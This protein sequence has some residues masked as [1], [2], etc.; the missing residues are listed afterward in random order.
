MYTK[1]LLSLIASATITFLFS[2][3][4]SNSPVP[5]RREVKSPTFDSNYARAYDLLI[6][7]ADNFNKTESVDSGKLAIPIIEKLVAQTDDSAVWATYAEILFEVGYG[8]QGIDLYDSSYPYLQKSLDVCLEHFGEDYL[9][10]TMCINKLSFYY[11]YIGDLAKE[12]ENLFRSFRIRRKICDSV[13]IYLAYGYGNMGAYYYNIGDVAKGKLF[14]QK[15]DEII[16]NQYREYSLIN[17]PLNNDTTQRVTHYFNRFPKW[18]NA[19]LTNI[20]R[21]YASVLHGAAMNYLRHNNV[22]AYLHKIS[23]YRKVIS[24]DTIAKFSTEIDYYG[25][26]AE[27]Y[28]KIGNVELSNTYLDSLGKAVHFMQGWDYAGEI[29]ITKAIILMQRGD[30]EAAKKILYSKEFDRNEEEALFIG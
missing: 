3:C 1:L 11:N 21:A 8:F 23:E 18:K 9:L 7:T 20:P 2:T 22:A 10:V 12:R 16:T 29:L 27:Y 28:Q 25:L 30:M 19:F 13:D 5:T 14:M 17:N 26:Q 6:K 4:T 24:K 15:A